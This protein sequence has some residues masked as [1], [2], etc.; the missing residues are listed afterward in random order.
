[1]TDAEATHSDVWQ[2]WLE[3]E[4]IKP[5]LRPTDS[6]VGRWLRL[7]LR[8]APAGASVREALGVDF[9]ES[10]IDRARTAAAGKPNLRSRSATR[11][12][13]TR[14]AGHVRRRALG[15]LSHQ[16]RELGSA[17]RAIEN[18]AQTTEAG[19]PVHLCRRP[20]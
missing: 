11:S 17:A 7:R 2:R 8:D 6:M 3:I 15:A 20:G 16:S 13:S 4:T 19:W 18:V 9:S 10:M 14:S 1:L 5:F 12:I